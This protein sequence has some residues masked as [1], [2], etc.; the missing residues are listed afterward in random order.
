MKWLYEGH[1]GN[2]FLSHKPLSWEECYCETCGDSDRELGT[3]TIAEDVLRLMADDIAA[4]PEDG[5]WDM[6]YIMEFLRD[7]FHVVPTKE[8]AI[9]FVLSNRESQ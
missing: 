8:Q 3:V 7:H 1:M 4:L 6:D 5:G 9:Q 2:L